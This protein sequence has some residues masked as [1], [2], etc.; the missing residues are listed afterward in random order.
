MIN[1]DLRRIASLSL[2][3]YDFAENSQGII[4]ICHLSNNSTKKYHIISGHVPIH[5]TYFRIRLIVWPSVELQENILWENKNRNRNRLVLE[6]NHGEYQMASA[7]N[8][9]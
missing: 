4:N 9:P 2:E 6:E 5:A 3:A 1:E 8:Y 7:S